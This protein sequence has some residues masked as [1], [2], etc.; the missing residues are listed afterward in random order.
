MPRDMKINNNEARNRAKCG[1]SPL[2]EIGGSFDVS[3][4]IPTSPKFRG[5]MYFSDGM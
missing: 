5:L 3:G 1:E 4:V 2:P